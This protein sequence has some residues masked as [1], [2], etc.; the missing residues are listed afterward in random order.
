MYTVSK[1]RKPSGHF[2]PFVPQ[3]GLDFTTYPEKLMV[4]DIPP[5]MINGVLCALCQEIRRKVSFAF[6]AHLYVI[7]AMHKKMSQG[8]CT[9]TY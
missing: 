4:V 8:T 6:W 3:G 5:N 7:A 2:V 1:V 9:Y